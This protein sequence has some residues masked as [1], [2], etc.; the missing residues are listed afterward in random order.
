M[1]ASRTG[2]T[3]HRVKHSGEAVSVDREAVKTFLFALRTLVKVYI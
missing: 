2:H 1:V 3:F